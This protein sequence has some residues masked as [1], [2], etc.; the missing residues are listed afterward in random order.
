MTNVPL[1][2][3]MMAARGVPQAKAALLAGSVLQVVCGAMLM[4]G[5]WTTIAALALIAFLV[6]ATWIFHNFRDHEG[7]E[8][9]TR[10]NGTVRMSRF[11]AASCWSLPVRLDEPARAAPARINRSV[12]LPR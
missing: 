9:A 11:S 10:I 3:G 4:V 2:T 7:P 8:R 5:L 12:A 6:V 1:L